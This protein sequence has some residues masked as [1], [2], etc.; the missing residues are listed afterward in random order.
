MVNELDLVIAKISSVLLNNFSR[1]KNNYHSEKIRSNREELLLKQ[2]IKD[3][4]KNRTRVYQLYNKNSNK[5]I[6][7]IAL[8]SSRLDDKPA[9]LIDYVF[10][11]NKFRKSNSNFSYAELLITFAFERGLEFQKEIGMV[12]LILYPDAENKSLIS[13]YKNNYGFIEIRKKVFIQNKQKNEKWLYLPLKD[14]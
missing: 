13:Y 2:I 6:G 3:A 11:T 4:S 5:I 8:S 10:I 1:D 7:L 14:K 12:N 9:L